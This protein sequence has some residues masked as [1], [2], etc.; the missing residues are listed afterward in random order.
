MRIVVVASFA[1]LCTAVAAFTPP[2]VV[3]TDKAVCA[4]LENGDVNCMGRSGDGELGRAPSLG[5]SADFLY[6]RD[7]QQ[8]RKIVAGETHICVLDAHGDVWCWG[9]STGDKYPF[10]S[11]Q[12]EEPRLLPMGGEDIDDLWAFADT[13]CYKHKSTSNDVVFCWGDWFGSST[14]LTF[15]DPIHITGSH[16]FACVLLENGEVWCAGADNK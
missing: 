10:A 8:G 1:V 12:I 15:S 6:V 7:V 9:D 3:M 14:R 4:L 2:D 11:N 5:D 16:N 13:T